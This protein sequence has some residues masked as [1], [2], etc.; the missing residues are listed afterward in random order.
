MK[1]K[2]QQI[3]KIYFAIKNDIKYCERKLTEK[4]HCM[5]RYTYKSF[6]F[7]FFSFHFSSSL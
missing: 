6:Q 1:K 2:N 4:K 7:V 5:D 3:R